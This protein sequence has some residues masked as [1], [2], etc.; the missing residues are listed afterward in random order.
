VHVDSGYL[1]TA[2]IDRLVEGGAVGDVV[3]RYVDAAGRIVDPVLDS[4]TV[5]LSLDDLRRASVAIAAIAGGAKRTI[6]AAVVASQLC[7]VLVTDES[8]ARHLLDDREPEEP[9]ASPS[10]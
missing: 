7:T 10:R 8:T 9:P 2:D 3:G 4:R 1:S 6:A 5:G